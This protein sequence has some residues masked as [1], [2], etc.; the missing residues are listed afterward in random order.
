M[1]NLATNPAVPPLVCC[2]LL[3]SAGESLPSCRNSSKE[4]TAAPA[5]LAAWHGDGK[6][7][8]PFQQQLVC[9]LSST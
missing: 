9:I 4:Y 2:L 8:Q 6:D 3:G 1:P 5:A 7:E